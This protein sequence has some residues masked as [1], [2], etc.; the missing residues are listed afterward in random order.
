MKTSR[1]FALALRGRR[2]QLG[3]SQEDV[4]RRAGVSR[5][6]VTDFETGKSGGYLRS[7][8][9]V[10]DVLGM[11]IHLTTAGETAREPTSEPIDLDELLDHYRRP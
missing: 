1:D 4:A 5:K 2:E 11:E 10:I 3:L 7:V 6:W 8:L 9:R